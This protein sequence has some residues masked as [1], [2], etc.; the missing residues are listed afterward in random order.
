MKLIHSHDPAAALGE[1][2]TIPSSW[3]RDPE[4]GEL[5]RKTVFSR[6]WHFAGRSEEAAK[7]GQYVT[8]NVGQEPVV[9]V[10]GTDGTLRGFSNLCRRRAAVVVTGSCGAAG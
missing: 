4:V 8:C 1:A 7:P 6:P 2:C 10:R 5:E 3:Y 9:I